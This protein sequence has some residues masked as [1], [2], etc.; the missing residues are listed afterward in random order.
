[1]KFAIRSSD[2]PTAVFWA[3]KLG[4][5]HMLGIAIG[6]V[7]LAAVAITLGIYIRRKRKKR[8]EL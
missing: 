1:M 7:L 5:G 6:V 2:G 4:N 8:N 3:G